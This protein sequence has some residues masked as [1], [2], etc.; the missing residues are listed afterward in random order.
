[1]ANTRKVAVEVT[2]NGTLKQVAGEA[3]KLNEQL[4]RTA[5][6]RK[7]QPRAASAALSASEPTT[8][9]TRGTAGS[10]NRGDARDFG[11]QAQGLGGLVHLYATFA[12]NVYAVSAAFNALSKAADFTNMEKAADI[13]ST[14]VG[15]SIRGLAKD[16]KNLTDGAISMSDALGSA[17]LAS[18]AGLTTKQVKELTTVAKGASIA[19]GR[20]MTDALQ[21]VFRGTIKIEP[22]L[23]DELG[24]MVKVNDAN[25]AYA[26][27]LGKTVST[28][29]DYERRQAFVNAVTTQGISK[30]KELANEA[31][32]PFSKLASSVQDLGTSVLT[33]INSALGPLVSLLSQ[34]P[35]ALLLGMTAIVGLLLKQAVPAITNMR[36]AWEESDRAA[37]A[38]LDRQTESIKVRAQ[39][40]ADSTSEEKRQAQIALKTSQDTLSK[41]L[42]D[43][44]SG[45]QFKE[46]N[47]NLNSLL[48]G[49][50]EDIEKNKGMALAAVDKAIV[51]LDRKITAKQKKLDEGLFKQPAKQVAEIANM[52]ADRAALQNLGTTASPTGL[53]ANTATAGGQAAAAQV[54]IHAHD[55]ILQALEK[56]KT[57]ITQ[58]TAKRQALSKAYSDTELLGFRNGMA[59]LSKEVD[60]LNLGP[61]NAGLLKIK[62]TL[63][64]VTV[65][66]SRLLG[67]FSVWGAALAIL[68]PI[69]GWAAEK[70][71]LM[72]DAAKKLDDAT[73]KLNTTTDTF[74]SIQEKLAKG[75]T[76]QDQFELQGAS[77]LSLADS[78]K[79]AIEQQKELDNLRNNGGLIDKLVAGNEYLYGTGSFDYASELKTIK[80]YEE[81]VKKGLIAQDAVKVEG[82]GPGIPK[83]VPL[84]VRNFN[85]L[86]GRAQS[87]AAEQAR[88]AQSLIPPKLLAE[89]E[90]YS[91]S[92]K[93][94]SQNL[95]ELNTLSTEYTTSLVNQSKELK[96]LNALGSSA[97]ATLKNLNSKNGGAADIGVFLNG[98]TSEF[99]QLSNTPLT[100]TLIGL[101]DA[102][103]TADAAA[104]SVRD[105]ELAAAS[106]EEERSA[107]E[108]KYQQSLASGRMSA[109][110][111]AGGAGRVG[112]ELSTYTLKANTALADFS[113]ATS[114]AAVAQAVIARNLKSVGSIA[115]LSGGMSNRTLIAEEYKAE[116]S[117][118][119]IEKDIIRSNKNGIKDQIKFQRDALDG[120]LLKA[121]QVTMLDPPGTQLERASK[122]LALPTDAMNPI[123]D[124]IVSVSS[125]IISL[126]R[127]LEGLDNAIKLITL[128]MT[129]P[130][131]K[132]VNKGKAKLDEQRDFGV[133]DPKGDLVIK[134]FKQLDTYEQDKKNEIATRYDSLIASGTMD[135]ALEDKTRELDQLSTEMA[136]ARLKVEQAHNIGVRTL[137]LTIAA[138][139]TIAKTARDTTA[140]TELGASTALTSTGQASQEVAINAERK[141][142]DLE[143]SATLR[144]REIGQLEEI[145]QQLTSQIDLQ[146]QYSDYVFNTSENYSQLG[147]LNVL[148]QGHLLEQ[149]AIEKSISDKRIEGY[150]A[151]ITDSKNSPA[152]QQ[153]ASLEI[154]KEEQKFLAKKL[155]AQAQ[156]TGYLKEQNELT[157]K[158]IEQESSYGALFSGEGLIAAA[159]IM[160]DR[161]EET[162]GKS[163]S[164]MSQ[165]ATGLVDAADTIVDSFSTM[166]QKMDETKLSWVAFTDMV[167]NT[168]S[169]MFRD[170]ASD[171]LKN[172]VKKMMSGVLGMFGA[173]QSSEDKAATALGVNSN[174]L[175]LLN[176]S[177]KILINSMRVPTASEKARSDPKFIAAED[178]WKKNNGNV[179]PEIKPKLQTSPSLYSAN[180]ISTKGAVSP[181]DY[182][183]LGSSLDTTTKA[184]ER[185][186]IVSVTAA[187]NIGIMVANLAYLNTAIVES[188]GTLRLGMST[189]LASPN[190]DGT[191]TIGGVSYNNAPSTPGINNTADQNEW[192]K[193]L[194]IGNGTAVYED[195]FST[196][197][198]DQNKKNTKVQATAS[199]GF[200][201]AADDM[202]VS[203]TMMQ[204]AIGGLVGALVTGGSTKG[205]LA[206][207]AAGVAT[208]VLT[209]AVGTM[210][211]IPFANGGIMSSVGSLPLKTY[212]SGGIANSPQLS[213]FGEGRKNEAYVP[214]PDNRTIP[215]TLKGSSGGT[216][217]G[218]T[219]ITISVTNSGSSVDTSISADQATNLSKA[220]SVSIKATIQE[221]LM[222]QMKPRGM[223]YG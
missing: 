196:Y 21:R 86:G 1:M 49:K 151:I 165:L 31:A 223:L 143:Y 58:V 88:I 207:I 169:D 137:G 219:N 84:T 38:S 103:N 20:D 99:Q 44:L 66:M 12:A 19:L 133:K 121:Q 201:K 59:S 60:A 26:K 149:L 135:L 155:Q 2:D 82:K 110:N 170:M 172:A 181:M 85:K 9:L 158:T 34:S 14:K 104:A 200:L 79:A 83:S 51:E 217:V 188:T 73:E 139:K 72:T 140:L 63:G 98:I 62:G 8:G 97:S 91:A 204:G 42:K 71:G 65:S 203:A 30:Y 141:A 214:L 56:E 3:R 156:L 35:V 112:A 163:K 209:K 171:M 179:T 32:N 28:L 157:L 118:G 4:D 23:L 70:L 123:R 160:A 81:S 164:A 10:S 39:A 215:V 57:A 174:N 177:I 216:T 167:R 69:L 147:Q 144:N 178:K 138:D 102:L 132:L 205:A 55:Q 105:R 18:S 54:S 154:N 122:Y 64:V 101:K 185:Q 212:S 190:Y 93:A 218:D 100:G 106:T 40:L 210:V 202:G 27:T 94:I 111:R 182:R 77:A 124:S 192:E 183:M 175:M 189:K 220:L 117:R 47:T 36:A 198:A 168:L 108:T 126:T 128:G 24:L 53:I 186:G 29:T 206:G 150:R 221:E 50:P 114:K 125:T 195:G 76:L 116:S 41:G 95:K 120:L 37:Q 74:V 6:P 25:S 13:L 7:V 134:G 146:K 194:A 107:A 115:S 176:D 191:T 162:M 48:W 92:T 222:K 148:N 61:M 180:D 213:L 127:Q 119:R 68:I 67:T 89:Q 113:L 87:D 75:N 187:D 96:A 199:T 80:A 45:K 15:T 197:V 52:E 17:S 159:T 152:Y 90:E 166:I 193:Q 33:T 136:L 161:I 109:I 43:T 78:I 184:I 145:S 16:M 129:D 142:G 208:G 153:K 130:I 211:G 22:E 46:L 173:G 131:S 5:Q 11:R